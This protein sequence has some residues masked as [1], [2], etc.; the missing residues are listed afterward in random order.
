ME[1]TSFMATAIQDYRELIMVVV[2]VLL[3]T[4]IW[5]ALKQS[6]LLPGPFCLIVSFC[7]AILCIIGMFEF[8][9]D[10]PVGTMNLQDHTQVKASSPDTNNK[11]DQAILLPYLALG[12][13]IIAILLLLVLTKTW[14]FIRS[15]FNW[16]QHD[17]ST[18]ENNLKLKRDRRSISK[19][20]RPWKI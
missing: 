14:T 13:S 3:F 7:V 19:E 20:R 6:S 8:G 16:A 9:S 17:V 12:I 10:E 2:F 4:V 1:S 15:Y 18:G 5:N 11:E